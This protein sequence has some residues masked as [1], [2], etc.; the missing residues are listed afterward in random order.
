MNTSAPA[1]AGNPSKSGKSDNPGN[2]ASPHFDSNPH[3]VEHR[4]L[5][6]QR[7][8]MDAQFNIAQRRTTTDVGATIAQG[9]TISDAP[10]TYPDDPYVGHDNFLLCAECYDLLRA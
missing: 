9:L 1:T 4:C 3:I 8:I 5:I 6:C 2:P 10:R 7:S